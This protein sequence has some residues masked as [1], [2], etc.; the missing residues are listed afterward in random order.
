M[1]RTFL[2]MG[3]PRSRT[4]WVANWLTH[5]R[6]RCGHEML[7]D[8]GSVRGLVARLQGGEGEFRGNADTLQAQCLPELMTCLPGARLVVI[9]RAEEAVIQ[10]LERLGFPQARAAVRVLGPALERAARR[11]G[12]LVLEFDDLEREES[13]R[14]L[15]EHV[16]PRE[17]FEAER[18]RSLRALN[19]QVTGERM[20]ELLQAGA[21]FE[22]GKGN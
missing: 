2:V 5:G 9:R 3:L 4:A 19:V 7:S 15:L 8:E 21:R 17:S 14:A 22:S 20:A 11:P 1:N 18:W 16:A 10:S 13:G 6:V 12:A